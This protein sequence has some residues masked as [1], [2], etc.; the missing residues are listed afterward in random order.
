MLVIFYRCI[1]LYL[2]FCCG[3][4]ALYIVLPAIPLY[5]MDIVVETFDQMM[6]QMVAGTLPRA[7]VV[8]EKRAGAIEQNQVLA[9]HITYS[10]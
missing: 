8:G 4:F 5:G 1:V 2:R 9:I 3:V 7:I 6:H 10:E